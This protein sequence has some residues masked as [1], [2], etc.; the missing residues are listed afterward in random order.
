M[1]RD[2]GDDDF[3]APIGQGPFAHIHFSARGVGLLRRRLDDATR[4]TTAWLRRRG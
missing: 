2:E 4:S 1:K 3:V